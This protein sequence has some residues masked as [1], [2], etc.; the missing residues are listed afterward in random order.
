MD[1]KTHTDLQAALIATGTTRIPFAT[2]G[3]DYSTHIEHL[4]DAT[5]IRVLMYGKRML[6]DYVNSAKAT[7]DKDAETLAGEWLTRA[8]DGELGA[9]GTTRASQSPIE[10]A[11][12]DIVVDYLRAS[13]MKANEARK[14][15]KNPQTAFKA[16]LGEKITL[17]TGSPASEADITTAFKT[18]WIKVETQAARVV[19]AS[20]GLDIDIA[21]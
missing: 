15:A 13:G 20:R 10:K 17:A 7:G 11:Q 1:T 5:I 18:N 16:L 4:P 3:E 9:S 21:L 19:E 8:K 14:A 2:G 12:R 6:N